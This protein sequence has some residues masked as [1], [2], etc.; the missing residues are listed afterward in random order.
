[1]LYLSGKGVTKNEKMATELIRKSAEAGYAEAQ[2]Q[3]G[4]CLETGQGVEKDKDEAL[5]WYRLAAEQG[6]AAAQA[7]LKS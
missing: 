1:M 2:Y 6:N 3:L 5:R 4:L 7:K